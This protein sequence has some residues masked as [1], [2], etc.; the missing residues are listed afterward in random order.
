MANFNPKRKRIQWKKIILWKLDWVWFVLPKEYH[1]AA[2][3]VE[4][5]IYE[6]LTE[7]ANQLVVGES[8]LVALDWWYNRMT[9]LT[10]PEEI[11]RALIEATAYGTR[12]IKI[13]GSEQGPALG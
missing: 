12:K 10:K 2:T 1:E 8:N 6:Y 7:K 4:T 13:S 9:L 11:Y 3:K 5:N